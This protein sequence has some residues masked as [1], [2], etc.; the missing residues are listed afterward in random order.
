MLSDFHSWLF[1]LSSPGDEHGQSPGD[2]CNEEPTDPGEFLGLMF[3]KSVRVLRK[4][5]NCLLDTSPKS[6][7]ICRCLLVVYF[8]PCLLVKLFTTFGA[9]GG[10]SLSK[11]RVQHPHEAACKT[12]HASQYF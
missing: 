10:T 11:C 6:S 4:N 12:I 2:V 7:L 9:D 3:S 5:M 8:L 1:F